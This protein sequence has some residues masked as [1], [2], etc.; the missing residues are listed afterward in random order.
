MLYIK[1]ANSVNLI[2]F[3][4]LQVEIHEKGKE[5]ICVKKGSSLNDPSEFR[6]KFEYLFNTYARHI[7]P[8]WY[9]TNTKV[10]MMKLII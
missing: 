3:K 9:P 5:S 4:V 1:K 2:S 7:I 10:E 6:T 8:A